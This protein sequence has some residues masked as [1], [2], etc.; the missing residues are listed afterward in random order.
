MG[1]VRQFIGA[2]LTFYFVLNAVT[3]LMGA[4]SQQ[5]MEL[6]PIIHAPLLALR[7]SMGM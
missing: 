2:G 3:L 5:S 1:I 7:A 6:H 4:G